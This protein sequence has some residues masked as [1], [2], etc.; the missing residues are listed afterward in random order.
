MGY[1]T[2]YNLQIKPVMNKTTPEIVDAMQKKDLF[3]YV[4]DRNYM[5]DDHTK[6]VYFDSWEEQK[7]Y[8]HD[9]DIEEISKQFPS[10]VFKL[11]C[12]GEDGETWVVYFQ[13]GEHELCEGRIIYEEPK[14]ILWPA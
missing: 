4:F 8:D 12:Y 3:H 1:Y 5:Y 2:K 10:C 11:D 14:E 6:T 7:W 9:E 13:N